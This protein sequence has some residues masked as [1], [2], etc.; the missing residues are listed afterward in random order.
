MAAADRLP[1]PPKGL[2]RAGRGRALWRAV[3]QALDLDARDLGM[4]AEAARTLDLLDELDAMRQTQGTLTPD[5]RVAPHVVEARQ[6]RL[7]LSRIL[8]AL[9]LPEDLSSP[10]ERP[11]K[12]VGPRGFYS[13]RR[14]EETAS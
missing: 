13:I 8:V 11:Q 2:K 4:L 3:T 9:R 1:E 14:R 10:A 5:G 7:A 6:Q 12:R